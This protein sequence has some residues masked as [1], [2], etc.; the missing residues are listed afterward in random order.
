MKIIFSN[1]FRLPITISIDPTN[2][3]FFFF[4]LGHSHFFKHRIFFK[5]S[6]NPDH[7]TVF[8]IFSADTACPKA[9]NPRSWPKTQN[10][11]PKTQTRFWHSF[12]EFMP[13]SEPDHGIWVWVLGFDIPQLILWVY[14]KNSGTFSSILL[15]I[16]HSCAW[17]LQGF[18]LTLGKERTN[19]ALNFF[20]TQKY[21]LKR[22]KF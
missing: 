3:F 4:F 12:W 20:K 15:S 5:H 17:F 11:K 16:Y 7:G 14:S 2:H 8:K 1:G 10:P 21:F 13:E 6:L 9:Q 18:G 19:L 22:I